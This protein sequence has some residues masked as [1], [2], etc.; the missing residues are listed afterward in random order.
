MGKEQSSI[1]KYHCNMSNIRVHLSNL[2]HEDALH[3]LQ[4]TWSNQDKLVQ[5]RAAIS[6]SALSRDVT[7]GNED[8]MTQ[9]KNYPFAALLF[10]TGLIYK[11]VVLP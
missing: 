11:V 5:N 9:V 6:I 8:H 2:Q 4:I 10:F 7:Q 3:C 1:S